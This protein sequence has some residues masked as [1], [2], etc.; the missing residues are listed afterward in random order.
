[1][2]KWELQPRFRQKPPK[3]KSRPKGELCRVLPPRLA[4]TPGIFEFLM[5]KLDSAKLERQHLVMA[6]RRKCSELADL[7]LNENFD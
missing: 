2:S 5:R 6:Y 7:L 3:V 4:R 1:M